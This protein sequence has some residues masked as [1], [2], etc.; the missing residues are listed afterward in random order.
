MRAAAETIPTG[1]TDVAEGDTYEVNIDAS[2]RVSRSLVRLD[3][4]SCCIGIGK[5]VLTL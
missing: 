5:A 4:G 2:A 3:L 1:E